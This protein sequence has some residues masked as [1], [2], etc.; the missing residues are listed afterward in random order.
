[1]WLLAVE[2]NVH[3]QTVALESTQVYT[4]GGALSQL[5]RHPQ[6]QPHNVTSLRG[7]MMA[8]C[9]RQTVNDS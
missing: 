8:N 1:M 2:V 4:L 7:E 6:Q 9:I 3:V 5:N